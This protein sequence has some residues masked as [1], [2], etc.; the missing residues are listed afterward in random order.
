VPIPLSRAGRGAAVAIIRIHFHSPET[1]E[2]I[3]FRCI[4]R[5]GFL[6]LAVVLAAGSQASIAVAQKKPAPVPDDAQTLSLEVVALQTLHR[7]DL[8]TAQLEALQRLAKGAASTPKTQGPVRVT[9]AFVKTLKALRNALV[10]DDDRVD[11]LKEK[12]TE[13]MDKDKI[14]INDRVPISDAARRNASPAIRLL[15]AGQV[16]AYLELLDEDDVDLLDILEE[17]LEKGQGADAARW[18]ALRDQT[19]AEA[20]WLIAGSDETRTRVAVKLLAAVLDQHHS[21]KSK[22]AVPD[23]EK[24]V[25]ELTTGIDPFLVLRNTMEREMAELL[26]N[27]QLPQAIQHTL[28]QR[29]KAAAK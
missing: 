25:Q 2:F 17:A 29:K 27:P 18:K 19:A 16:L 1:L 22:N 8:N 10:E 13:V 15:T 23:L 21:A 28:Q 20:A 26:S 4:L 6:A 14:Q 3:M 7:L 24:Q 5:I 12:L 9:P 11:D